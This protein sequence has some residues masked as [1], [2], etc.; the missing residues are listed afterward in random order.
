LCRRA[1]NRGRAYAGQSV[2]GQLTKCPFVRRMLCASISYALDYRFDFP[3]QQSLILG[4]SIARFV[5]T[6]ISYS[7][8]FLRELP[9]RK[10]TPASQ[11]STLGPPKARI[12]PKTKAS[13]DSVNSRPCPVSLHSCRCDARG[14]F[15]QL[16]LGGTD[17]SGES[18]CDAPRMSATMLPDLN[19]LPA[20]AIFSRS[21]LLGNKL[22][23]RC[24]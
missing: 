19:L 2:Q 12:L 8:F 22:T 9:F 6:L 14:S 5:L 15:V 11:R 21:G 23:A 16:F 4:N 17:R 18:S 1:T 13:H 20:E 3:P 24:H 10:R 7:R